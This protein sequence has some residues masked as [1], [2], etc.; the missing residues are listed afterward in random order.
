MVAEE[1]GWTVDEAGLRA[2]DGRAAQARRVPGS[3]EVAVD[4]V[5]QK[6]RRAGGR[7]DVPRLR[8]DRSA[9]SKI[10][11]LVAGGHEVDVGRARSRGPVAVVTGET[12]FYGEQGG[13]MGD[14]GAMRRPR[15]AACEVADVKRPV[16]T[17]YVHLGEV[18]ERR[19]ARR[20]HASS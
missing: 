7:D 8:G 11:A 3:G 15:A 10:I 19:A 6:R 2:R 12:P 14:A 20:R 16:P 17:L 13:Q 1:R 9:T 4:G 5:F 18:T